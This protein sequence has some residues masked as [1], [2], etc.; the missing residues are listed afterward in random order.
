MIV[1]TMT[2]EEVGNAVMK[3]A[4]KSITKTT[5]VINAH[6]KTFMRIVRKSNKERIDFKPLSFV[7]DGITFYVC[8]Y[9]NNKRDTKK[10][11][12]SFGVFAHIYYR[13]TNWYC[14]I[15]NDYCGVQMYQQHFFERYIERHLKDGSS[16]SIDT[17]RKYF[18]ET[19]YIGLRK[20]RDNPNHKDCIYS[21]TNIGVCCGYHRGHNISIWLTY[22][23]KETLTLGDKKEVFDK[24]ADRL[25]QVG[26]DAFGK[27]I[28]KDDLR[29]L[30]AS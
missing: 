13:S 22:I 14:M 21:A 9:S 7:T 2:I 27:R 24:G 16:V 30:F 11:G 23:D 26:L 18:K 6:H 5:N 25:I 4:K 17:V 12:F 19:N 15:I 28:Y 10:Y 3:A 8:V 29:Y 1:D 20:F